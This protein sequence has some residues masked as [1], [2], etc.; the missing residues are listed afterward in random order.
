MDP[1]IKKLTVCYGE[2]SN[3]VNVMR[4]EQGWELGSLDAQVGVLAF[5][6]M[7][8]GK[9]FIDDTASVVSVC[10]SFPFVFIFMGK[11]EVNLVF[12]KMYSIFLWPISSSWSLESGKMAAGI[13]HSISW[14]HIWLIR[15]WIPRL[16]YVHCQYITDPSHLNFHLPYTLFVKIK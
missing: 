10:E 14:R 2:T 7:S 8:P 1:I 4:E 11:K 16:W 6:P 3:Q 9:R 15:A 5:C 13:I 12:L